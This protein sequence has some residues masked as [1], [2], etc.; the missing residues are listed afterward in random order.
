V[1][2]DAIVVA[3][4]PGMEQSRSLPRARTDVASNANAAIGRP[5]LL[6]R[7]R[8]AI[9]AKH[10]SRRTETAYVDWIRRYI[11]FHKKR[12]PSELG[13]P[14]IAAFLT[15]LASNR[16]VSAS[17]QNQALSAVLFLY[18]D[19]L[20][21]EIGTIDS[22]PRARMPVRIPV[23]LSRDE[24]ARILKQLNGVAWIV[25]AL[26]YG[27]GLRL[28][29]CLELRV[30]DLD[31]E[32]QQIVIRR[33]KGQKDRPTVLP[34]AVFEPLSRH[35]EGVKRQHQTDLAR[36][37][38]R[39]VLPFALDRKYPNA[40]IE[41]GWQFVF[42]ASRVCTDP[43]WEPPTRFHLHESVV[44]K[45]VAHAARQAGITKRVGPHTFRHSFA[46]HLLEDGY[47]IRTV[48]ELLGHADV[49]TTMVYTHVLNR[50]PL[51]VRSP[52]DRL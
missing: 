11:V 14:E 15:W 20:R 12:H 27:A 38:G 45:A 1:L 36:G 29:E 5:K 41:W 23:V 8:H 9:R 51:G 22:V 52:V 46:T 10:Y 16:R 13:A 24:V 21:I 48:Q 31:L 43:R 3:G 50:G 49:S 6:D 2:D 47:D 17:T 39:V 26:L 44:Q 33:G 35:L 4:D 25:V 28:N 30:K 18:R 40:P 7:V 34:T 19:V 37:F 32:R 42:P